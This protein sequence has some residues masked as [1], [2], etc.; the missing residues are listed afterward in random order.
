MQVLRISFDGS[1][2]YDQGRIYTLRYSNGSAAMLA[3]LQCI[4][5]ANADECPRRNHVV[6][7]DFHTNNVLMEND[8]ITGVID[9][10]GSYTGDRAFD[11]ATMLFYTWKPTRKTRYPKVLESRMAAIRMY[12]ASGRETNRQF[13]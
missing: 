2:N 8:R 1:S 3:R 11:L 5:A 7:W 12:G 4:V 13:R 10:E 6:H 9:W